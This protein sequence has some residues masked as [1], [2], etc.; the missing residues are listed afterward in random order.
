MKEVFVTSD[1]M[2]TLFLTD[3][4]MERKPEP[5][6]MQ[7]YVMLVVD[8]SEYLDFC[9][10]YLHKKD[11]LATPTS[12]IKLHLE[13]DNENKLLQCFYK[14]MAIAVAKELHFAELYK[15]SATMFCHTFSEECLIR[16]KEWIA[17]NAGEFG[18]VSEPFLR[19]FLNSKDFLLPQNFKNENMFMW[20]YARVL[21]W[22]G[23]VRAYKWEYGKN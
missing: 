17:T 12:T 20:N 23:L 5:I 19:A 15:K 3:K 13:E 16:E 7:P 22:Y 10:T 9:R 4:A 1:V 6:R 21:G 18:T 11:Y 14:D 2:A 8:F